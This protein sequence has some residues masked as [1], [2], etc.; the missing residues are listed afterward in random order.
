M[1]EMVNGQWSMV[2][3][4]QWS[5]VNDGQQ[6]SLTVRTIS[7]VADSHRNSAKCLSLTIDH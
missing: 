6:A 1:R 5:V 7:A 3:N 2:A 4:S